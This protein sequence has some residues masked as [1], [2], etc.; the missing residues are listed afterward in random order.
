MKPHRRRALVHS[1]QKIESTNYEHV[2]LKMDKRKQG[3]NKEETSTYMDMKSTRMELKSISKDIEYMGPSHM[4]WKQKKALEKNKVVSLGGKAAF[5]R[6]TSSNEKSERKGS[7]D[8]TRGKR[9]NRSK[10]TSVSHKP[11][12]RTL[13]SSA[14]RFRNGVLDV[15]DLVKSNVSASDRGG[16]R[17]YG[18]GGC[19]SS[20]HGF[21]GGY[22]LGKGDKKGG[23]KNHGKKSG[24]RKGH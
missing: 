7:K 6:S 2:R 15:N 12:D 5:K 19:G 8:V 20:S 13:M 10:R 22:G 4:T 3:N 9:G 17:S 24:R 14:G 11:E 1:H 16:S 23:K 18:F 21:G